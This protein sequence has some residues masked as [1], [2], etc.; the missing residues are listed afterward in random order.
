MAEWE[1]ARCGQYVTGR[2]VEIGTRADGSVSAG[3]NGTSRQR[4]KWSAGRC[5]LFVLFLAHDLCRQQTAS[6]NGLS[7]SKKR[8]FIGLCHVG[9]GTKHGFEWPPVYGTE[10]GTVAATENLPVGKSEQVAVAAD[11]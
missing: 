8:I 7:G 5:E 9:G 10:Q 4:T 6:R 1:E 2:R 11:K 3:A